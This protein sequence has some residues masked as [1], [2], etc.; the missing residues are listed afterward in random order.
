M[1]IY[2]PDQKL[3]TSTLINDT[4]YSS[5]FGT[6]MLG[7]ARNSENVIRFFRDNFP[8]VTHVIILEQIHST[9]ISVIDDKN[10]NSN[11]I[12]DTDG[13]LTCLPYTALIVRNADCVPLIFVD[14]TNGFIGI[15]H[16]G[17][18]GSLKKMAGKMV[19]NFMDT[20]SKIENIKVA[21]G[22]SIGDCCYE[23]DDDHYYTFREEF[24][25]FTNLIFHL[26]KG[27]W[28]LNLGYLNYLQLIESGLNTSQIDFF[29]FC[30]KCDEERFSS[31]RRAKNSYF[32]TM[33]NFIYKRE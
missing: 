19:K 23:V 28:H 24:D 6:K 7:N 12:E 21:I 30:T 2:N 13:L 16:Q 3:F 20:G 31:K 15:S 1:I 29:P 18:R 27:R 22:P 14:K 25:Q 33:F 11:I 10:K 9:N 26:K 32:E 4:T 17:W 5:G 8:E